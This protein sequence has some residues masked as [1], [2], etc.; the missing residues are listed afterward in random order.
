MAVRKLYAGLLVLAVVALGAASLGAA[1]VMQKQ[2]AEQVGVGD[3]LGVVTFEPS[4]ADSPEAR[5]G[6]LVLVTKRRGS[7]GEGNMALMDAVD[8]YCLDG[9]SVSMWD[10][11]PEGPV[12]AD[13]WDVASQPAGTRFAQSIRCDGPLPNEM[14]IAA[15]TTEKQAEAQVLAALEKIAGPADGELMVSLVPYD[16]LQPKYRAFDHA[17][18][19]RLRIFRSGRCQDGRTLVR[20]IVVGSYPPP[21][22][23]STKAVKHSLMMLGTGMSCLAL[24]DEKA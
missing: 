22:A 1:F 21:D 16:D 23:S 6:K 15:G 4:A 3:T 17:L 18:G 11:E 8:D 13:E 19:S 7:P 20:A 14:P 2:A 24:D 12:A 10:F 9:R 5:E